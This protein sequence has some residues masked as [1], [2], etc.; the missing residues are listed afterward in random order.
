[1]SEIIGKW[2][3]VIILYSGL[4][5]GTFCGLYVVFAIM[6]WSI[7]LSELGTVLAKAMTFVVLYL[8]LMSGWGI[9]DE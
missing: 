5:L 4:A 1:M 2:L 6:E 9:S 7:P 3:A 8:A